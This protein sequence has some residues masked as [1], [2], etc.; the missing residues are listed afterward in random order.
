MRCTPVV[1]GFVVS[2]RTLDVKG[3]EKFRTVS[4][5]DHSRDAASHFLALIKSQNP[6]SEY[7]VREEM[8]LDGIPQNF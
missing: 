2:E 8:G 7:Y 1:L 6:R 4:R 3:R 5:R